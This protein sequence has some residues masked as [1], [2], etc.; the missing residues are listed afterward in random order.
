[1]SK[2]RTLFISTLIAISLTFLTSCGTSGPDIR[3]ENAW[4]RPDP[5]WEQAAGYFTVYNDG[6]ELDTLISITTEISKESM[7]HKTT[8]EGDFH[9]MEMLMSLPV[10][11]GDSIE[12]KPLSYHIMM[13]ELSQGLEYGQIVTLIFDFEIS[14]EI[15][16]EAEIRA[17]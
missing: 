11:A 7:M 13:T 17:Q 3:I 4:I 16:V 8:N 9:K 14:G 10:P 12:F 6:N 1:M 5:L 2:K 15:I